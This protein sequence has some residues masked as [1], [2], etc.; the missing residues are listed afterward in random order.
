M[1][2][3]TDAEAVNP[4]LFHMNNIRFI[5]GAAILILAGIDLGFNPSRI[6]SIITKLAGLICAIM[7]MATFEK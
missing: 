5:L 1:E 2:E 4:K 7:F 3:G 6:I